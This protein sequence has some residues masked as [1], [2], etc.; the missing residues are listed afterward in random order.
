MTLTAN[1]EVDR[2]VD[3]ELR[4]YPVAASVNIFKGALVGMDP[5]GNVRPFRPCDLFVGIAYEEGANS[6]GVAGDISVRVFTLGD[7]GLTLTGAAIT[8]IG[9]AVYASDDGT[10]TFDPVS[11]SF[12]GYVQD[13]I[14]ANEIVLRLHAKGPLGVEALTHNTAGFTLTAAQSGTVHTNLGASGAITATLPQSP[15][16][17]TAFKFVCMADQELRLEPGVVPVVQ[18]PEL[19]AVFDIRLVKPIHHLLDDL[20]SELI[21]KPFGEICRDRHRHPSW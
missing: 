17:G 9:R 16:T 11:N 15:P 18:I 5:T 4:E 2:L 8:D 13:F 6:S 7:F 10:V 20:V 14:T 21:V 12:I 19:G 1:L 3:Q